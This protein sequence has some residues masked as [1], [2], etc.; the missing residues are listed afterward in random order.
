VRIH[1]RILFARDEESRGLQRGHDVVGHFAGIAAGER[2][3]A[4]EEDRA[5]IQRGDERDAVVLAQL[6]VFRA[7]TGRDVD[8][9]GALG[10]ADGAPRDDA[11][12]GCRGGTAA[13]VP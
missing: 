1:V 7:A 4:V 12:R 2:S 6:L 9:A 5:F 8:Q 3:E 11:M 10:F 13:G